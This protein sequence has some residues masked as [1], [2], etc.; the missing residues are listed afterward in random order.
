MPFNLAG[1]VP[2]LRQVKGGRRNIAMSGI[3]DNALDEFFSG[4]VCG[5]SC[6]RGRIGGAVCGSTRRIMRSG[7]SCGRRGNTAGLGR[8]ASSQTALIGEL[9]L[10]LLETGHDSSAARLHTGTQL[11][12][13]V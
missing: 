3:R 6:L 13:I 4:D 8:Q 5:L 7:R 1:E 10:M 12:G 2:F 11:L 9:V